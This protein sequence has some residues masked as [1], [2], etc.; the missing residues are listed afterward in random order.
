MTS[1]NQVLQYDPLV[2]DTACH[3]RAPYLVYL[4]KKY[5]DN[6]LSNEEKNY[7]EL[8]ALLTETRDLKKDI[9]DIIIDEKTEIKKIP[10]K[11]T[12]LKSN[13]KKNEFIASKKLNV[14]KATLKFLSDSTK[15][16][17]LSDYTGSKYREIILNSENIPVLPLYVSSKMMLNYASTQSVPLVVNLKRIVNQEKSYTLD[18]AVTLFYRYDKNSKKIIEQNDS[19]DEEAIAIDMVDCYTKG[20]EDEVNQFLTA[21]TFKLFLQE[22]KKLDIAMLIMLCAVGHPQFPALAQE[23]EGTKSSSQSLKKESSSTQSSS[24]TTEEKNTFKP[25]SEI[26]L[27]VC[28]DDEFKKLESTARYYGFFRKDARYSKKSKE[29]IITRTDTC[30]F[31]VDHV[32]ASTYRDCKKRTDSLMSQ[33]DT[34]KADMTENINAKSSV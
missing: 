14:A 10:S 12:E 16:L 34:L 18:G 33:Q 26:D 20:K 9:F 8:C 1:S 22:F 15:N 6:Q 5:K 25:I 30:L 31:Y 29:G 17:K 2:S 27:T 19:P 28:T 21:S 23:P 3:T 11:Y 24:I 13:T 4:S 7:L 32:Y